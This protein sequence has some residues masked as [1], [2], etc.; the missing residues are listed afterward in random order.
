M[1]FLLNLVP[2]IYSR[3]ASNMAVF[4]PADA[5]N[6]PSAPEIIPR[7][8]RLSAPPPGPRRAQPLS[9]PGSVGGR[10]S[11]SLLHRLSAHPT[12]LCAPTPPSTDPGEAAALVGEEGPRTAPPPPRAQTRVG[13]V[14]RTVSGQATRGDS[15]AVPWAR[16]LACPLWAGSASSWWGL[17]PRLPVRSGVG[18]GARLPG[19]GAELP[20]PGQVPTFSRC[21]GLTSHTASPACSERRSLEGAEGSF[22]ITRP[23]CLQVG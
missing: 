2:K 14:L 18:S 3:G 20:A 13:H 11:E 8:H 1:L 23:P 22:S 17:R 10:G 12:C 15:T 4:P 9:S 19:R 21:P 5:L 6:T 16:P 7:L